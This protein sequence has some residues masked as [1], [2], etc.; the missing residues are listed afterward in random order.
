M[1]FPAIAVF[2]S[3]AASLLY[4][5]AWTRALVG[6]T[7]AT[8]VAQATVLAVFMAGL[9]LGSALAG[10][11]SPRI[12]H[13][14]RTYAFVE[15]LAAGLAVLAT[16]SI[17]L[18]T[19]IADALRGPSD[20]GAWAMWVQLAVVSLGML[21]PTTLLGASLPLVL[22]A[23]DRASE[24][25]RRM[26]SVGLL[27]G[28]NAGGAAFGCALGGFVTLERVGLVWTTA[29]GAALA[30]AAA[31]LALSF[32]AQAPRSHEAAA[33]LDRPLARRWL[34]LAAASGFVGLGAEVAFMRMLASVVY[35]TV[36]AFAEVLIGVLVGITVGGLL[37]AA[38][39]RARDTQGVRET[40]GLVQGA[41]AVLLALIPTVI[42]SLAGRPDLARSI[43]SGALGGASMVAL[44]VAVPMSLTTAV[45][46][47][48]VV[49]TRGPRSARALGAVYAA[50]TAGSVLGSVVIGFLVL[51]T[52]GLHAALALLVLS[53]V[54]IAA[55]L[56]T[57]T[58]AGPGPAPR[59]RRVLVLSLV[60]A[61]AL[62]ASYRIPLDTYRALLPED[63]RIVA[64][65]EG[66]ST[67]VMITDDA[68][69]RRRLWINSAWVATAGGGTGYGH[70]VLGHFPALLHAEPRDAMGIAL[71]TG[72]TFA[73]LLQH[74]VRRFDCVEINPSVIALTRTYFAEANGGLLDRPEVSVHIED[75]RAYLRRTDAR[76]DLL[77]LEPLQ[78]WTAGTS[79]LYSREFYRDAQA[80][81][82]PDGVLLQ[83]IPLY[84]QSAE[85]TRAMVA[86]A[87]A[88]F[89]DVTLWLAGTEGILL[90][91]LH[92]S[93]LD[94][95]VL[96]G[97]LHA[98]I[99]DA[100]LAR[101][102][103]LSG[104][105]VLSHVVLG[106]RGVRAWVHGSPPITDDRPFLEFRAA[107][108]V[109]QSATDE[110]VASLAPFVA[111][112]DLEDYL[113][114]TSSRGAALNLE[115]RRVRAA[116][117][118]AWGV[119]YEQRDRRSAVLEAGLVTAPGSARLAEYYRAYLDSWLA[120]LE[121]TG[122]PAAVVAQ[123]RA[124]RAA[125]LP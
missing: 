53:A 71:G 52:M 115:A 1:L 119:P 75:G 11:R 90:A 42:I 68:R 18:S 12:L 122:A 88:E 54:A 51:P 76:Y 21:A 50:N 96:E 16:P 45:L 56:G 85:D 41:A 116:M 87:V 6:A 30:L 103:L 117:F 17:V 62:L 3:G 47:L 111:Q 89:A 7:S 79:S 107:R 19:G 60:T 113:T 102:G 8:S 74:G 20:A 97:R 48:L 82:R 22:E 86:S 125:H 13:P 61:V 124:R 81:L 5:L 78:A 109:D 9:G 44:V 31:G 65:V 98:R 43:A 32:P 2:L 84:G 100:S 39:T 38:L 73:A 118:A 27:Y 104:A 10:R 64:L 29:I 35:N 14:S 108:S 120:E 37:A 91:R 26:P 92:S 114:S 66:V 34:L 99:L 72:Q 57:N 23:V 95:E 83:W 40:A 59:N 101:S 49:V 28:I 25:G 4:Q 55:A 67:D 121:A 58:E 80:V 112:D 94:P 93:P 70:R 36:Y 123:V 24:A 106:P 105:D 46:P 15:A 69:D 77:V 33:Q 110:I 63:H